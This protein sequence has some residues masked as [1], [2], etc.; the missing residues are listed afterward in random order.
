MNTQADHVIGL[1]RRDR[2]VPAVVELIW[3]SL[4]AEA[5]NIIVDLERDEMGAVVGVRITDDGHGVEPETVPSAFERLG[6]SWKKQARVSPNLK[7]LM[8]GRHGAGRFRA[9]AL[10]HRVSWTTTAEATDGKLGITRISGNSSSPTDFDC[11]PIDA[12]SESTIGT[13]FEAKDP[14]EYLNRLTA[15][16]AIPNMTAVFAVYLTEHPEVTITFDGKQLDPQSVET[17]RHEVELTGFATKGEKE[18]LLRIIEWTTNPTRAIHFCDQ[19]GLVLGSTTPEIQTPN[20]HFTAYILWD[21]LQRYA[22]DNELLLAELSDD[23]PSRLLEA[24]REEIKKYYKDRDTERR[25]ETVER[26][27]SEGDYPYDSEPETEVERA[28]RE[29]FDFVATS[30]ARKL[31]RSKKALRTTLALLK[32]ALSN[33]PSEVPRIIEEIMPLTKR[34]QDD[35]SRLLDRTS[36]SKL[37][38]ANT[39]I[40]NR[41][42][43]LAALRAMVFD[44]KGRHQTK[45]RKELHRILENEIWVFG[46]EYS[47]MT[48]DKGLTEALDRHIAVL[49][50]SQRPRKTTPVRRADGSRGIVDLMLSQMRKG[51]NRRE[52]LIIELKRPNVPITQKEVAQLKSYAYAVA[53]DPQFH[54]INVHWDFWVVSSKLDP[55]VEK[56]ANQ[57]DRPSG[58]LNDYGNIRLW[59]KTWSDLIEENEVRL[60]YFKDALEYDAS[61]EHAIDYLNRE[62]DENTIPSHLK[63]V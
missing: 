30:A 50:P 37:I 53:E 57:P 59:A 4:D 12:T 32:V 27:K 17:K 63:I 47:L 21:G 23:V 28:E 54:A 13:V 5:S 42:D 34:E 8:N 20:M 18:P 29:T 35:L 11:D 38:Q 40:T 31:P 60:K 9:F 48:S 25:I 7:R 46:D 33:E 2:P 51:I 22:D 52:H 55:T 44:P 24:A 36:M 6:G 15:E 58:Q 19:S 61:L 43:F 56:D 62:H 3:N 26:W 16:S 10:G 1:A 49:R 41:L 14:T 45:E 39:Q